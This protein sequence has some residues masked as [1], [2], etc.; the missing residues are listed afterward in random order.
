M[1]KTVNALGIALCCGSFL[2]AVTALADEAGT[3]A[4]GIF[5]MLMM[6]DEL[7]E[8]LL[9]SR[10]AV[11]PVSGLELGGRVMQISG[12]DNPDLD[13]IRETGVLDPPARERRL[14][15]RQRDPGDPAADLG[16][17]TL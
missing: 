17:G 7:R 2:I 11:T 6:N 16:G 3:P 1:I 9:M 15:L 10:A 5:E 13:P 8:L 12:L 14:L 4:P